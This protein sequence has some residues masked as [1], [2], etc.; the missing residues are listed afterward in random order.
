MLSVLKKKEEKE[1]SKG[2]KKV[3]HN[4]KRNFS[5]LNTHKRFLSSSFKQGCW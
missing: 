3:V 5:T 4:Q 2:G 1:G